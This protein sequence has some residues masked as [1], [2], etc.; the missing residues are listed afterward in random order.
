[1]EQDDF[2]WLQRWYRAHCNG[3]WEHGI[4][5][6]IGTIDNPGWSIKV[7]LED[8]ELENKQFDKV[9][10]ERSEHDWIFCTVKENNCE[11]A[12]GP[13]NLPE[14]LKIFHQWAVYGEIPK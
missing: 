9:Y 6:H 1:M 5:I 11:A 8:T 4:G 3:D 13:T 12:C 7:N 14:V 2:L 10:I